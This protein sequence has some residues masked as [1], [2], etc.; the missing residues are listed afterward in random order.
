[1]LFLVLLC[2]PRAN[3]T[4]TLCHF[5]STSMM[6]FCQTSQELA[7]LC[8][9]SLIEIGLPYTP[10]M[11][12][13]LMS[14]YGSLGDASSA[15]WMFA[16]YFAA[17]ESSSN[18]KLRT[19]NVLLGALGRGSKF[20]STFPLDIYASTAAKSLD[21][22][23][24]ATSL[25]ASS[26]LVR[27]VDG[28]TNDDAIIVLLN[29]MNEENNAC[30]KLLQPPRPDSQSYCVAA[31]ALQYGPNKACQAMDLF[32]NATAA[33]NYA[34]GRFINAV[35]RCFGDDIDSAISAWKN[36]IR[37]AVATY[38]KRPR[39]MA[40]SMHKTGKKNLIAA[41]NGLLY[42]CGRALKP[43]IAVR[44]VYAM[45]KEGLE[46]G[47]TSLNCYRSGK[48][49]RENLI[50]E[51]SRSSFAESFKLFAPYESLLYVECT[52]Y[53]RNDR[54]RAGEKRVRIIL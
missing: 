1:M 39:K 16:N 50:G 20:N 3:C 42:V 35:F 32:R 27:A 48:R 47:E 9:Q 8:K 37:N 43:D 53:D 6:G 12:R 4:D 13:A 5:D 26:G 52:K 40:S 45:N 44:I 34:D 11:L 30:D 46:P 49:D 51:A 14:A 22:F 17:P 33:K 28:L 19:W 38:E 23:K 36:E 10:A 41:Y 54:R 15:V 21:A 18:T 7:E 29:L 2:A 24:N 25:S 31:A